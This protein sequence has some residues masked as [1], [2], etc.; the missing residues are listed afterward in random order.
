MAS[1]LGK[2]RSQGG[3]GACCKGRWAGGTT[4]FHTH[5]VPGLNVWGP[6]GTDSAL[7]AA[8]VRPALPGLSA[9]C[10]PPDDGW[11]QVL[12]EDREQPLGACTPAQELVGRPSAGKVLTRGGRLSDRLQ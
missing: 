1:D 4:C 6:L 3:H 7:C 12:G 8:D 9:P 10:A 2:G 5:L 11:T